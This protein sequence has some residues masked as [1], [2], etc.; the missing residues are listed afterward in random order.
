[1]HGKHSNGYSCKA[2]SPPRR[3]LH[4]FVEQTIE[5]KACTRKESI[6][7]ASIRCKLIILLYAV[8]NSF[9]QVSTSPTTI[10]FFMESIVILGGYS[11]SQGTVNNL[12]GNV[13]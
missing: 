2:S 9:F 11:G 1:M 4:A 13:P 3:I 7:G 5:N 8:F 10:A 12:K 6:I